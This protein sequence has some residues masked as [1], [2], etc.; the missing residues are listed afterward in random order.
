MTKLSIIIPAY[1]EVKTLPVIIEKIKAVDLKGIEKEII[2]VDDGSIDGTRDILRT[3]PG[4]RYFFHK[5]NLGKGGAVKTG[6]ENATGDIIIIQ[7]ADLEYE[8]EDYLAMIEPILSRKVSVVLGA[9]ISPERDDRK[10]KSYYW[11]AWLGNKLITW[12]TNWLYWNNAKD[13]EGCYKAFSADVIR[14]IPIETNDFDYDNELICKLLKRGYKTVDVP[15]R[16]YPRN[17]EAGKKIKWHH[18]FK[19]IW[20][21][22]KHRFA[23]QD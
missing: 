15:I 21:I 13:Y 18:G 8:P 2:V 4:I 12:T 20:T 5:K 10:K 1:N 11:L 3:I 22:I 9:R 16:Y 19:I 7:D 14:Q 23:E 17:Y 6:I